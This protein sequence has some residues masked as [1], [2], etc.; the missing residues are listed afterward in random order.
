MAGV[1]MGVGFL[2]G[3]IMP[4]RSYRDLQVGQKAMDLADGCYDVA[5]AFPLIERFGLAA[6]LRDSISSVPANIAEGYGRRHRGDY[7]RHLSMACGSP[8]ESETHLLLAHRRRYLDSETLDPIWAL[9]QE[10]G[11][12][13]RQQMDV[14]ARTPLPPASEANSVQHRTRRSSFHT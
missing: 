4:L 11:K 7:L 3:A 13:L 10:V 9:A 2:W 12:M 1:I 14:L 8:A 6:Q 5:A